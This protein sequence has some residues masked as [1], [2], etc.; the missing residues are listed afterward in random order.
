L[1]VHDYFKSANASI[2]SWT[3][4]AD[5]I[6]RWLR[7]RPYLLAILR[8]V[9]LN[10]PTHH[11]G[12][13][14][15]SVIRGVLTRWT[16]IYFAY[17]RLLQLRTALM[18]FV[19]DRRL[20]E[21]GTT[22]SHARTR[23]MVDELK[24]PL[25]WHHLSRQVIVKRHLEP[26]AIAANIT[27]AN[28]CR[29]DQVLLTFGFVY[30]FFTLLTDLED[31]PFRIAVCQSLERRW[32]KADQDV[33]IAAV[34][35]N[36]WLKMRPFQPNMQLFTEAAFHVILS[37][38]WRRFYPDEPVPGSLFTE[39]QEYFDNTGNFESLHMTMD[40]ISSQARD[41]V[42]FHMFHS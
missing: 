2:L 26:L 42:C 14:P 5:E 12:N 24:K 34:V 41:R 27:Q 18:V 40:A 8:D 6:I 17:R 33:F 15:L 21:S 9:Q 32:A 13:S 11:H 20:F 31:H 39:I 36:P 19:E 30:N 25:L 10:L 7:G 29:L 23:E 16:S 4:I 38:L 1:V 22:E 3:K 35:L 28:D 37:R